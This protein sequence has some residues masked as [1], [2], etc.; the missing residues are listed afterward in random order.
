M[1]LVRGIGECRRGCILRLL[2]MGGGLR[3]FEE[4]CEGCLG[5]AQCPGVVCEGEF[6]VPLELRAFFVAIDSLVESLKDV[7][8]VHGALGD[9]GAQLVGHV[10]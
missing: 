4:G 1:G 5:K 8:R 10:V 6:E 2:R 7:G 3:G 9:P